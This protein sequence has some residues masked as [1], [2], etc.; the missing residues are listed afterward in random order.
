LQVVYCEIIE[1]SETWHNLLASN[2]SPAFCKAFRL[3]SVYNYPLQMKQPMSM[4]CYLIIYAN[5]ATPVAN[6][7]QADVIVECGNVRTCRVSEH[8]L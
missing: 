7:K 6:V 2:C 1:T 5:S 3:K 4:A 8:F